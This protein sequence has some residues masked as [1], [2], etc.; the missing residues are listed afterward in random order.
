MKKS[1]ITLLTGFAVIIIFSTSAFALPNEVSYEIYASL[2]TDLHLISGVQTMSFTNR[3]GVELN[4]LYFHVVSNA[5]T[6][7]EDT[8]YQQDLSRFLVVTVDRIYN[9]PDDTAFL[10]IQS[11][12]ANG[13]PLEFSINDTLMR[14]DLPQPLM[15]DE[16]ITIH[17]TF[18]HDLVEVAPGNEFAG[19]LAVR[20][21]FRDGVYT[22]AKWYPQLV[23]Y[24]ADG[25]HLDEYRYL[26]EFYGNFGDY[27]LHINVP[28]AVKV[29][30]SGDLI[31]E[32]SH[33]DGTKT[34][35]YCIER[36]RDVA[37]AASEL[38]REEVVEWEGKTIRTLWLNQFL[39][40]GLTLDSFQYFSEIFGE[41]AYN[42]LTAVQVETAGGMEYPGIIMI[43]S[44]L[45]EEISHEVAHEWFYAGVGNNEFDEMWLDEGPTTFASE[46]YRIESRGE[47][48]NIRRML[49]FL[50]RN[51][52]MLSSSTEFDAINDFV[53][54]IYA[55]GAS[56]FWMLDEM[57]GRDILLE[58]MRTY[59]E[60]FKYQNAT[61][62]DLIDTFESVSGQDLSWFFDQWLTT[63]NQLDVALQNVQVEAR[64]DG[65]FTTTFDVVHQGDIRMPIRVRV[66]AN[67]TVIEDFFW[68]GMTDQETLSINTT[69]QPT[70]IRLDPDRKLLEADRI[71]NFWL[72]SAPNTVSNGANPPQWVWIA[73]F[74]GALLLLV[75]A[76]RLF[77]AAS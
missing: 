14:A 22:V 41:Y 64:T 3:T 71:D 33:E 45:V 13:T 27:T 4:E 65:L 23:V 40:P 29:G 35:T 68:E 54:V 47:P 39:L 8:L 53:D 43:A 61:T 42:T 52:P 67:E 44:G 55:K 50:E 77:G 15:S 21:G 26:G 60:T 66:F 34:Q 69:Q 6:R 30:A 18:L 11:I 19:T 49:T 74:A 12:S 37:W 48:D 28:Q 58:S 2:N 7:G 16:S 70:S 9:D 38:F 46:L 57:L 10:A 32:I 63:T 51:T 5:F 25:W 62:Q 56:I 20:S 17:M 73:A 59:Y 31:E 24:D 72:A 36:A 75:P 1:L 76:V